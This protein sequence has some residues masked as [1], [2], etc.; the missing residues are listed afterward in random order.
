MLEEKL[1][2][3]E[4]ST[5][6]NSLNSQK[7]GSAT[8]GIYCAIR[9]YSHVY[10]HYDIFCNHITLF[11]F[12]R[13]PALFSAQCSVNTAVTQNFSLSSCF[14]YC[15]SS[16]HCIEYRITCCLMGFVLMLPKLVYQCTVR[17]N[18]FMVTILLCTY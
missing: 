4:K 9:F 12:H 7:S 6:I 10:T 18:E 2:N 8:T 15:T 1:L 13:T 3:A 14:I 17:I 5:F 16:E 11:F